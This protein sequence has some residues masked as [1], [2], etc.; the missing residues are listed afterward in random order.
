MA[1][2][3]PYIIER[4]LGRGGGGGRRSNTNPPHPPPRRPGR[5]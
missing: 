2:I 1:T 3:G 5:V 4:E